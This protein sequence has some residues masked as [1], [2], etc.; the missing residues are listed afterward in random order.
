[1]SIQAVPDNS[2]IL[3][4]LTQGWDLT[5]EQQAILRRKCLRVSHAYWVTDNE[6]NQD[7]L[8][9]VIRTETG[10][11]EEKAV[12]D[13]Q[14]EVEPLLRKVA[15]LR[16]IV[17]DYAHAVSSAISPD[18]PAAVP[19]DQFNRAQPGGTGATSFY[20]RKWLLCRSI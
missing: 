17:G 14:I 10:D 2:S 16:G 7:F 8:A 5:P 1:M 20:A 4:D 6:S 13:R 11:P 19:M 18:V 12:L 3:H 15:R 9:V